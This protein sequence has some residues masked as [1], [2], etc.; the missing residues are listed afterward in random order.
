MRIFIRLLFNLGM[1]TLLGLNVIVSVVVVGGYESSIPSI[2]RMY[3]L[4]GAPLNALAV[5]LLGIYI[6][7]LSQQDGAWM[8]RDAMIQN[9]IETRKLWMQQYI[10]D[11]RRYH[12]AYLKVAGS[13][14]AQAVI[15]E[16]V[17]KSVLERIAKDNEI[18]YE[19]V[20]W[21]YHRKPDENKSSKEEQTMAADRH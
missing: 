21:L 20:E 8:V 6:E 14:E 13:P 10:D 5:L 15:E 1:M 9:T 17:L 18:S 11:Q 19:E 2:V 12:D 4:F 7:R 16:L 3:A